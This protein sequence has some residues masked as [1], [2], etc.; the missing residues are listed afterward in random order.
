V[1]WV[2]GACA[3]YKINSVLR[4]VGNKLF[5][6]EF[7]G[8]GD[9]HVLGLMMWDCGYKSMVIPKIIASHIGGLTFRKIWRDLPRI[10]T[11]E[12]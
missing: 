9:D 7:F 1:T 5:I 8:Y 4:C 6:N 10:S 11:R 3:L 12:K 2:S